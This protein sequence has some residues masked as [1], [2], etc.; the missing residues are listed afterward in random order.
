MDTQRQL[1]LPGKK[2]VMDQPG[3]RMLMVWGRTE[4]E[5]D[6]EIKADWLSEGN[7]ANANPD[8][9]WYLPDT[10]PKRVGP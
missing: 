9:L 3:A 4:K 8:D 10:D 1:K 5:Q 6:T 2:K 7:F